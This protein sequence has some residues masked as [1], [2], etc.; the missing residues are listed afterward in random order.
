MARALNTDHDLG[1]ALIESSWRRRDA[2]RMP[3]RG[4]D[5]GVGQAAA[6][7]TDLSVQ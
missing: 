5:G 7:T 2:V 4:V 3:P 1:P 6:L